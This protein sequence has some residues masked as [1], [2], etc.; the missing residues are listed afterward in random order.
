M[1]KDNEKKMIIC[2]ANSKKAIA[3]AFQNLETAFMNEDK[4][5]QNLK[6]HVD[7][8]TPEGLQKENAR[9]VSVFDNEISKIR[10][11]YEAVIGKEKNAYL[12][13]MNDYLGMNAKDIDTDDQKLL[14]AEILTADEIESMIQKHRNNAT[15]LR[16]INKYLDDHANIR[17]EIPTVITFEFNKVLHSK[18]EKIFD[19][20]VTLS[21]YGL[22]TPNKGAYTKV[23]ARLD[24]Y[25]RQAVIDLKK[26]QVL[27]SDEEKEEIRTLESE[28][29]ELENNI[30]TA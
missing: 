20:F 7:N 3:S 9:I 5:L 23:Q 6:S 28:L 30:I 15:M 19:R 10:S 26:E 1:Y 27:Q 24:V 2:F 29:K 4:S 18:L 16:I 14:N 13:A 22:S 17:K 21:T 8:Y 11:D 25:E 12:S